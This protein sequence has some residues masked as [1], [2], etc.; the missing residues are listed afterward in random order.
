MSLLTVS[1]MAFLWCVIYGSFQPIQW[2]IG[3]FVGVIALFLGKILLK[4]GKE[5]RNSNRNLFY[6]IR[7]FS[8]LIV[9]ML[10]SSW[11]VLLFL[12]R[13]K[14]VCVATTMPLL[15]HHAMLRFLLANAITMT[16][17]TITISME[18]NELRVWVLVP[19]GE[20]DHQALLLDAPK[21]L[22]SFLLK[23]EGG[24]P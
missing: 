19:R 10:I 12:V 20:P 21:R 15:L 17:G 7:F 6:L 22:Q 23:V 5:E 14:C 3:L 2:A 16:P 1:G 11:H 4:S 9:D 24:S 13:G 8:Q 18:T